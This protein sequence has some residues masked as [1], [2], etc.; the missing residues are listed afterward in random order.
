LKQ[1]FAT[2]LNMVALSAPSNVNL[3]SQQFAQLRADD[4]CH[5]A[6]GI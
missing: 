3:K 1:I 5:C 2:A 6:D 4:I